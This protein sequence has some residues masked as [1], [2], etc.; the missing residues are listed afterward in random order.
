MGIGRCC[1]ACCVGGDGGVL[2]G[3]V[4][5]P[6]PGIPRP[7]QT[8]ARLAVGVLDPPLRF[9]ALDLAADLRGPLTERRDIGGELLDLT[10]GVQ[11]EPVPS[12]GGPELRV[13]HDGGVT[14]AVDR[15]GGV[16]NRDRVDA[17]PLTAGL[18]PRVDLQ[19]NM[20]VRVSR[21]GGVMP[22]RSLWG[23]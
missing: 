6:C 11:G 19:M 1:G 15:T 4:F 2:V 3:A 18:H 13:A 22:Y 16:A 17:A 20:A 8:R 7:P 23:S 12:E 21:T 14:D 9:V 10:I 5:S